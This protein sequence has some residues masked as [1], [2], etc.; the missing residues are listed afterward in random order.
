MNFL[1]KFDHHLIDLSPEK[2]RKKYFLIIIFG[3]FLSIFFFFILKP[4]IKDIFFYHSQISINNVCLIEKE[5]NILIEASK[6]IEQKIKKIKLENQAQDNQDSIDISSLLIKQAEKFN[7]N[8]FN[9]TANILTNNKKE[10]EIKSEDKIE[11]IRIEDDI[12]EYKIEENK[13]EENEENKFCQGKRSENILMGQEKNQEKVHLKISGTF[14][15]LLKFTK[16][17]T[18]F[19]CKIYVNKFIIEREID[20]FVKCNIDFNLNNKIYKNGELYEI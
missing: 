9:F 4:I 7:L 10:S 11:K 17:L 5:I 15:N 14:D 6:N 19:N 8:I 18:Q 2:K 13:I 20:G 3:I 12:R 1:K 16:Y